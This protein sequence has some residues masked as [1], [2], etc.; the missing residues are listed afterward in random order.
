[1]FST[2]FFSVQTSG[3]CQCTGK[4]GE[5]R[6]MGPNRTTGGSRPTD[7]QNKTISGDPIL[8]AGNSNRGSDLFRTCTYKPNSDLRGRGG[9]RG[10]GWEHKSSVLF[11]PCKNALCALANYVCVFGLLHKFAKKLSNV[12]RQIDFW[13]NK[14]AK[15][16]LV[17][18]F[19]KKR[20][21]NYH[22]NKTELYSSFGVF[23]NS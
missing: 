1:L 5:L 17:C 21:Q 10:R 19:I 18:H 3:F 11:I 16:A 9:G 22:K 12:V 20:V 7:C 8:R 13:G 6:F 14:S 23:H 2:V 4:T 15:I